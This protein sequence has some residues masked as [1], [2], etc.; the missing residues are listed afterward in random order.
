MALFVVVERRVDRPLIRL[1][2]FSNRVFTI[3]A[4]V[5]VIGIFAYL[6]TAYSTSIG[7]SAIQE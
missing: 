1:E 7:L 4:V 5:T 2:L 3:S 6:G